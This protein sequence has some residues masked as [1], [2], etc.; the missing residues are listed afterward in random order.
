MPL[1]NVNKEGLKLAVN[2]SKYI[3]KMIIYVYV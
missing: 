1:G 2:I 3:N